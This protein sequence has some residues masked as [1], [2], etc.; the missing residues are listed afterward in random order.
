[1]TERQRDKKRDDK[2][3]RL[4]V[5]D[6]VDGAALSRTLEAVTL[7]RDLINTPAND[8]GPAALE[9]AVRD[10]A[11]RHG[12]VVRSIIGDDL[13]GQNF[14]LIHAVGRRTAWRAAGARRS[15]VRASPWGSLGSRSA[16]GWLGTCRYTLFTQGRLSGC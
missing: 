9:Q 4:E 14:P 16:W 7:A 10:L 11:V 3:L 8:M 5:P 6:G 1:M 15:S 2:D 13:L 12:A